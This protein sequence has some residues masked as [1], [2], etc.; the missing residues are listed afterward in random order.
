M[1]CFTTSPIDTIA[2]SSPFTT[3]GMWRTRRSVMV[4]A[5]SSMR[6]CGVATVTSDVMRS[7]TV[8]ARS[9]A[10]TAAKARTTSRSLTMPSVWE[11]SVET[12]TAPK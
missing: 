11:P 12:T 1:R 7:A 6:S 4:C 5:V 3:T 9:S 8:R 2:A 10:P